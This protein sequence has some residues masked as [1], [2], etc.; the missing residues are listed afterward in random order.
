MKI[1]FNVTKKVKNVQELIDN[2]YRTNN[3]RSNNFAKKTYN[4]PE[5]ITEQCHSARRSF[6][7][8]FNIAKTY[9][10]ESTK[11]DVMNALL[12]IKNITFFR[13]YTINK[14]VFSKNNGYKIS[15]NN[16]EILENNYYTAKTY[17]PKKLIEILKKTLKDN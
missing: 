8:L 3:N 17:T 2:L 6:E 12:N 5:L 15:I 4:E 10:P 1:Y 14:I 16:L 13:C 9:F 11:V 7:D